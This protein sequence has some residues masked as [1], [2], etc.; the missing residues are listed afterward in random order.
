MEARRGAQGE[1]GTLPVNGPSVL[2]SPPLSHST[3]AHLSGVWPCRGCGGRS[4]AGS[5]VSHA[6]SRGQYPRPGAVG[7]QGVPR[8]PLPGRAAWPSLHAGS[9]RDAVPC[10]LASGRLAV[11]ENMA[12][13]SCS[14]RRGHPV[15]RTPPSPW[16]PAARDPHARYSRR[17][18]V[19][20]AGQGLGLG[21][22]GQTMLRGARW[23]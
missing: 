16:S 12:R 20:L 11:L 3:S 19:P 23:C 22:E 1:P 5:I 4:T 13:V 14:G 18:R 9:S 21:R 17:G 7:G 2:A 10:C 8:R 6:R 15:L